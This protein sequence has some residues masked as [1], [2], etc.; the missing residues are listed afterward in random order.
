MCIRSSVALYLK[1]LK[2]RNARMY[3]V[4]LIMIF[5]GIVGPYVKARLADLVSSSK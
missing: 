2:M 5:Y 4:N 1:L 3:I